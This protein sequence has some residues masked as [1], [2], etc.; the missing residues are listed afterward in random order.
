M[1]TNRPIK[2]CGYFISPSHSGN[3]DS[4]YVSHSLLHYRSVMHETAPINAEGVGGEAAATTRGSTANDGY[5]SPTETENIAINPGNGN[6]IELG[7]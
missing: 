6:D 4:P 2:K 5:D 3:L 7:Q 1:S